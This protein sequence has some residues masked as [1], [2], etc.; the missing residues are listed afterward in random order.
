VEDSYRVDSEFGRYLYAKA[1]SYNSLAVTFDIND[2]EMI[3]HSFSDGI[4][5]RDE[6]IVF[7]FGSKPFNEPKYLNYWAIKFTSEGDTVKKYYTGDFWRLP[8]FQLPFGARLASKFG[9]GFYEDKDIYDVYF[10]HKDPQKVF[11][12]LG[13][14]LPFPS[15]K[16]CLYGVTYDS[17]LKP[18]KLKRYFYPADPEI[19]IPE[20]L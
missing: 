19:L 10:F 18:L 8:N 16:Y 12:H 3:S 5:T 9:L 6:S 2:I 14:S 1:A 7:V 17:S 4:S 11:D 13:W 15:E 20:V